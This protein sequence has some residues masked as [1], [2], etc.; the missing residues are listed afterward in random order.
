M[1]RE[2]LS[3]KKQRKDFYINAFRRT[4]SCLLGSVILNLLLLGVIHNRILHKP[5]ET[6]YTSD[7]IT[8]P[9]PLKPFDE[10]NNSSTPLL[11]NDPLEEMTVRSIPQ[12]F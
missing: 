10:P 5:A 8:A 12:E 1:R 9:I 7:G 6:F 11:E 3:D 2:T 4:I